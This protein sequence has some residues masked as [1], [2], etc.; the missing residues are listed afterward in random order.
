MAQGADRN[1][2]STKGEIVAHRVS[3]GVPVY[4][5]DRYL[6][7]ALQSLADQTFSDFEVI[8]SDNGSTD[9][10]RAIVESFVDRDDRFR[11]R[12]Q[13]TN[14]GA[15]WNF[16]EVARL[17]TGDYFKWASHDDV[18]A[19]GFLARC[20]DVLDAAPDDVV[21]CYPRT[22]MIDAAGSPIGPY[23]DELDLRSPQPSRRFDAYLRNYTKS[24]A[25]FGLHRRD[26][27]ME[28]RLL[29]NYVSSDLVLLAE[30]VLN[31]QVWEIPEELFYRRQH[32]GMSR[33]ANTTPEEVTHWFDPDKGTDHLMPRSRLFA[34][35]VRAIARASIS[36]GERLRAL[37]S[38]VTVWG[39]TYWRTM[40]GEVKREVQAR[41]R[42][43][44]T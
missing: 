16:N 33:L 24:N 20:V 39:P 18:H 22:I 21:L 29:G 26:R 17:A 30:I 3:I 2:R 7:E 28:T 42:L 12:R 27:L 19:P 37:R 4:N 25:I 6:S 5:G 8:V 36:T 10:T 35:D 14:R 43:R 23:Q 32:E 13:A 31:G 11:Y 40:G 34:E 15:A 1:G 44:G 9:R 41:L 38:L